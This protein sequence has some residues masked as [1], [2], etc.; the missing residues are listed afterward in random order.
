MTDCLRHGYTGSPGPC[1]YHLERGSMGLRTVKCAGM[2]GKS[3]R[4]QKKFSQT[5]NPWNVSSD[6]NPKNANEI[7]KELM[8]DIEKWKQQ[9]EL[10]AHCAEVDEGRNDPLVA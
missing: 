4:R 9:D 1:L 8:V 3:I 2:C 6:G 10:C 5:I 7:H